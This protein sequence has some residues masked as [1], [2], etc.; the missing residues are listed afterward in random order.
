MVVV[1]LILTTQVMR[2][3]KSPLLCICR[4][5]SAKSGIARDISR[6]ARIILESVSSCVMD[7]VANAKAVHLYLG[8][9]EPLRDSHK[10]R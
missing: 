6:K 8:D 3:P 10:G 9:H 7:S 1:K 5:S 2:L 4:R